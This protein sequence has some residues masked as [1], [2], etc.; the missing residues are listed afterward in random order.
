MSD[1]SI[2]I[3]KIPKLENSENYEFLRQAGI[4]YIQKL[5]GRIWTDYNR[6]DPG[7]SIHE[8]MCYAITDLGYRTSFA[9]PD[10]LAIDKNATLPLEDPADF[11]TA[12]E[13]LPVNPT[14]EIDIRKLII[15]TPGVRN[16]WLTTAKDSEYPVYFDHKR[17][18]LTIDPTK[19]DKLIP[20]Q[21][22]YNVLLEYEKDDKD[23]E[24]YDAIKAEV[25]A[26]VMAHRNLCEDLLSITAIGYEDIAVCA[27]IEVKQYVDIDE[28]QAK[29]Y[30]ILIDYFTP[31]ANFY[32][33]EEMLEGEPDKTDTV[34]GEVLTWKRAPKSIDQ[35]FEGPLLKHGF[36]DDDE[37]AAA[38][39]RT[40]LHIS[41]V[42]NSIMDI[43]G[44][45]AV[46]TI[47]FLKYIDGE[48]TDVQDWVMSLGVLLAPRLSRDK[49]KFIFYKGI[50]PYM[51]HKESVDH[52]LREL[53]QKNEAFRKTGHTRDLAVPEGDYRFLADYYPVQNDF[54]LVYGIGEIGLSGSATEKRQAQAKQLK[55][56]LLLFEQILAN[57]LAQLANLKKLFSA[58]A[59]VKKHPDKTFTYDSAENR[60]YF[61][62]KL[63]E[64]RMFQEK[65]I[66]VALLASADRDEREEYRNQL[67]DLFD[68]KYLILVEWMTETDAA[69]IAAWRTQL[70]VFFAD[71]EYDL[72]ALHI[73]RTANPVAFTLARTNLIKTIYD[74]TNDELT[75]ANY[76]KALNEISETSE[77]FIDRRNRFMDHLMARFCEQMTDYSLL[78]HQMMNDEEQAGLRLINDKE[79]FLSDYNIFSR[80][81]G[82]GFNYKYPHQPKGVADKG[83][84]NTKN[85]A[86]MKH[87][88]VRLLGMDEFKR[89]TLATEL[90]NIKI[91]MVSGEATWHVELNDP[92]H[93]TVVL[94]NSLDYDTEECAE[95]TLLYMLH[96]GDNEDKYEIKGSAGSFYYVLNNDCDDVE[97]IATSA[98]TNFATREACDL[99]MQRV[100]QFFRD[101][102]D[103]ESFH[104]VEHIQLRPRTNLDIPLPGCASCKSETRPVTSDN[105]PEYMFHIRMLTQEERDKSPMHPRQKRKDRWKFELHDRDG[106]IILN[107][108]GYVELNGCTNGIDSL[109]QHGTSKSNYHLSKSK[110]FHGFSLFADNGQM[111]AKSKN[112]PDTAQ[113]DIAINKLMVFFAFKN[114]VW[115][116]EE[117]NEED[118]FCGEDDDP[119]SFQ[120]SVILPAWP[121]RFRNIAFRQFVEKTIRLETP[122]H[123]HP[124]ICWVN[125]D[126]MRRFERAYRKWVGG[127]V[128]NDIPNP[129]TSRKLIKAMYELDNVYPAALL[130]SCDDI[131]SN[132][133]Q[134][135]LDYTS[136]GN[137]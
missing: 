37:L 24:F 82:K 121:T 14:S 119:Y 4:Q 40:E 103:V 45:V 92:L 101:N 9:I 31:S 10:L 25:R 94:M 125:L 7:I 112:Y 117:G 17:C 131:S 54:P 44:V 6:H 67:I 64:I 104:L 50:L 32:T 72:T 27:D 97:I 85:V 65:E 128:T 120:I 30:K 91:K 133:P 29:I 56:Y 109:R 18:E 110:T 12:A 132:E 70:D 88:I 105:I 77:I 43:E 75:G 102:C 74:D 11:F 5:S 62:N 57:Y 89:R 34:T 108:E 111:I 107:S 22:L 51:A 47:S 13:I 118:L 46:K 127:L 129:H 53:Q 66:I 114:D 15:D 1:T 93:K 122:A 36:I 86:G 134:V 26:A 81:R 80:D 3:P 96:E 113:R 52:E 23:K 79:I 38:D 61:T 137:L 124:K 106:K 126:Q 33:L 71:G 35:I 41:D 16:A 2:T 59:T 55:A 78:V 63:R 116:A 84:W 98:K 136:L 48:V 68:H 60:T 19:G 28:V 42:I 39:L 130:H 100:I 58:E 95:S 135:I 69:R 87:R 49:S 115:N 83:I 21:G 99:E 76:T 90:L 123:I 20:L 73:M 8:L